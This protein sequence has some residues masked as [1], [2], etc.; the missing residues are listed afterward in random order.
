MQAEDRP[1]PPWAHP[2]PRLLAGLIRQIIFIDLG[3][4]EP[5][6]VLTDELTGQAPSVIGRYVNAG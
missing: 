5:T 1:D 2:T 3:H 4:E 6:V